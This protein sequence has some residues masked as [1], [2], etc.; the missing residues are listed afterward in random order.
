MNAMY[1]RFY[2]LLPLACLP[3]T[4][5]LQEDVVRQTCERY[6]TLATRPRRASRISSAARASAGAR[7]LVMRF[8]SS[9][10]AE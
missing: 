5:D 9:R 3:I 8:Y 6:S 4:M 2:S 1:P 7:A 10:A